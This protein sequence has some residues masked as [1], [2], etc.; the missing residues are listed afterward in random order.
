[1]GIE[2]L[3]GSRITGELLNSSL[4]IP[5]DPDLLSDNF[6][7]F[8]AVFCRKGISLEFGCWP[9]LYMAQLK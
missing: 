7:F 8:N 2:R 6:E 4:K 1:M 3:P 9:V 5:P